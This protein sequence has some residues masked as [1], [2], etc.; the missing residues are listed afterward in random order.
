MS[1]NDKMM[2]HEYDGIRELDNPLP[3]WWIAT[4]YITI[5]FAVVYFLH[6]QLLGAPDLREELEADMR[7]IKLQ[8]IAAKSQDTGPNAGALMAILKDP[9]KLAAGQK[10]FGEKCA[11]CHGGKAE[12]SIG[13][14][15][16]DKFWL[17]E[18]GDIV[19][20]VKVVGEGVLDKGMPPFKTILK[21]DELYAVV[22]FVKSLA[23]T[24]PPNAKAP[25]GEE[26][27]N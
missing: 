26:V 18:K 9:S 24:N 25:Q 14:N 2:E 17:H 19:G 27:A 15:L 20:L 8:Q 1:K 7:A 3:G 4:F 22:A 11:S 13:P 23:G 6:Y 16:T 21:E 5:V 10:V 12:G